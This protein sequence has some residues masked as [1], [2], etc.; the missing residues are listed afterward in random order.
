MHKLTRSGLNGGLGEGLSKDKFAFFEAYK[1]PIPERGKTAC[2]M[3]SSIKSKQRALF[4][5]PFQLDRVSFSTPEFHLPNKGVLRSQKARL[6]GLWGQIIVWGGGEGREG[7]KKEQQRIR[8][9]WSR[10]LPYN[11]VEWDERSQ[12]GGGVGIKFHLLWVLKGFP[13]LPGHKLAVTVGPTL[14]VHPPPGDHG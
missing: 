10:V 2:K 14:P 7:K 12:T 6:W 1:S 8:K 9:T 13:S 5:N 11:R 4:K 3:P